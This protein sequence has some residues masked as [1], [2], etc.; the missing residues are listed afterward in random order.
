MS[1]YRDLGLSAVKRRP[2]PFRAKVAATSWAETTRVIWAAVG[3]DRP[4]LTLR[5]QSA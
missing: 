5:I 2:F 1:A 3:L 4:P